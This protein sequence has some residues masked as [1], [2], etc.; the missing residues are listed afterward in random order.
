MMSCGLP[1]WT[2]MGQISTRIGTP[3]QEMQLEKYAFIATLIGFLYDCFCLF[4]RNI[5]RQKSSGEKYKVKYKR[6]SL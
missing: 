2:M 1:E 3:H 4:G 6:S 5:M